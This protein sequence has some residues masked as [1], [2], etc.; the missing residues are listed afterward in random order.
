MNPYSTENQP[1]L[2][3]YL[4]G[5]LLALLLTLLAFGLAS[6]GTDT[7]LETIRQGELPRWLSIACVSM[8]AVLQI[9]VHLRYFLHLDLSSLH[10]LKTQVILFSLFIIFI[11]VG[12]TLWIMYDLNAQMLPDAPQLRFNIVDK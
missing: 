1:R 5:F 10:N 3:T 11:L 7:S 4:T 2:S 8:L 6:I 9:L 12:G